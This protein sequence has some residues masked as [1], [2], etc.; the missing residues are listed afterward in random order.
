MAPVDASNAS[1]TLRW[2]PSQ[3]TFARALVFETDTV[4][5]RGTVGAL[6][7]EMLRIAERH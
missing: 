1:S 4:E 3:H 7:Y 6:V 5:P 2:C